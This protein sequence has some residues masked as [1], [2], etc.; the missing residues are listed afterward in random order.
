VMSPARRPG[1]SAARSYWRAMVCLGCAARRLLLFDHAHGL[2]QDRPTMAGALSALCQA[3]RRRQCLKT[4]VMLPTIYTAG[5][6]LL[7]RDLAATV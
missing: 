7:I 3:G 2:W 1:R 4:G 5:E 6:L